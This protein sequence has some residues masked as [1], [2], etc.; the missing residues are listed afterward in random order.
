MVVT[1]TPMEANAGQESKQADVVVPFV[2]KVYLT[3]KFEAQPIAL[4]P[5]TPNSQDLP[6]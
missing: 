4:E 2:L 6:S 1:D 3:P 5:I